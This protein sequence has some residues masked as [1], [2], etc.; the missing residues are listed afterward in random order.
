M[1]N[2]VREFRSIVSNI[3]Q[4]YVREAME[5]WFHKNVKTVSVEFFIVK[6]DNDNSNLNDLRSRLSTVSLK[7]MVEEI[8]KNA[9][10]E[11]VEEWNQGDYCV[12]TVTKK[13]VQILGDW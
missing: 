13:S 1:S 8:V 2:I 7:K 11:K 3:N 5:N 9:H 10:E 6:K 12:G 4:P